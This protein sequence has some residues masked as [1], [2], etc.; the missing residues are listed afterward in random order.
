MTIEDR[1]DRGTA[2][3]AVGAIIVAA[4]ASRRMAGVDKIFA[5][6]SGRP[7]VAYSLEAIHDSPQV[8]SIVLVVAAHNLEKGRELVSDNG[9]HKVA[10]VCLGGQRRQDS[11]R[12]GL[13]R[14][15]DS[16][17]VIVHDGA[18][19]F[20]DGDL[21]A[22]GLSEAT[23][24][25]SA[26]PGVPPRD[27]IKSADSELFVTETLSR[28]H[29]WA[30]QT[31]QV[32]RRRLLAEAHLRIADEATDDAAMVERTGEK[33]RIFVGYDHNIKLTTQEDL[34]AAEAILMTRLGRKSQ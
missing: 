5:P 28:D 1:A 27:T 22:R 12:S 18:R 29:L 32:F 23:Q 7:V 13:D 15:P 19:P 6:L 17:W 14:L 16:D 8:Q 30:I 9:W 25:G 3:G 26:V 24:T 33:V 11:V 20:I 31:P 4:G 10:D 34:A 21:I 2:V